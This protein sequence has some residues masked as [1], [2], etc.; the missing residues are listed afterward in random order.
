MNAEEYQNILSRAIDREIEAFSFYRNAAEKVKD[1]NLKTLFMGLAEEENGHRDQLQNLMKKSPSEL[2]FDEKKDVKLYE[3]LDVPTLT[4]DLTPLEG[5]VLAI[6]KELE[7]MQLY[8]QLA[9]ANTDQ[10]QK[11][12]F[13]ELAKMELGHKTRLEDIYVNMAFPEVW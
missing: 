5:L 12:I 1:S 6:R 3:S 2:H 13:Q 10:G 8:T 7:A 9:N 4:T 11:Q